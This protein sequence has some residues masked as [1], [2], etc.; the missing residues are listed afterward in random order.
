MCVL[1]SLWQSL[2]ELHG[3]KI[4]ALLMLAHPT[5]H[6]EISSVTT[7]AV[8]H[9]FST[10]G[11]NDCSRRVDFWKLLF[12]RKTGT[13][14]A[15]YKSTVVC[16]LLW[17]R[18]LPLAAGNFILVSSGSP[19]GPSLDPSF[20]AQLPSHLGWTPNFWLCH[21]ERSRI[22][23]DQSWSLLPIFISVSLAF[24]QRL[25][26]KRDRDRKP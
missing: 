19:F 21:I 4:H 12:S 26:L 2:D 3:W 16:F 24:Y 6:T 25:L 20:T 1:V 8:T 15:L 13:Y 9:H 22:R 23:S 17:A 5:P 14:K 10:G 7:Y 11:K 18:A